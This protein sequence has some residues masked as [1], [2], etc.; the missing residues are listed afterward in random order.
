MHVST[1]SLAGVVRYLR[2]NADRLSTMR[3]QDALDDA[4]VACDSSTAHY[5]F[6]NCYGQ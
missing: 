3:I 1:L 4:F 6:Y 5:C 2:Q